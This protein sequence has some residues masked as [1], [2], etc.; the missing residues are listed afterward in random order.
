MVAPKQMLYDS[1][2]IGVHEKNREKTTEELSEASKIPLEHIFNSRYY[3][4]E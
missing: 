4:S 3:C 1:I 2:K